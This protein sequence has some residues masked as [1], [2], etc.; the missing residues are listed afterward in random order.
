MVGLIGVGIYFLPSLVAAA[1]HT[2]NATGIFL[3]NL[4]LGWTGIGWI[5]AFIMAIAASPHYYHPYWYAPP[6]PPRH[7][8]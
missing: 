7:W 5:I 2:H 8:Y 6:P 4:F 1:R 3:L